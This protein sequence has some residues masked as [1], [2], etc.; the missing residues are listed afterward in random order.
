MER[1]SRML[2]L[3]RT[4]ESWTQ[5]EIIK[6][7]YLKLRRIINSF[8]NINAHLSQ[9]QLPSASDKPFSEEFSPPPPTTLPPIHPPHLR[10]VSPTIFPHQEH[11]SH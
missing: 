10:N 8:E 4:R 3:V 1:L 6:M 9:N 11:R 7:Y 2:I 5:P